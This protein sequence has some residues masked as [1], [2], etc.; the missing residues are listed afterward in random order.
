MNNINCNKIDNRKIKSV[1]S[2]PK[3]I[4]ADKAKELIKKVVESIQKQ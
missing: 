3:N 1:I 4:T 2:V